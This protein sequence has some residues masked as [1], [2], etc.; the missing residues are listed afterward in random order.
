MPSFCYSVRVVV[1]TIGHSTR[2]LPEFVTLLRAHGITAVADV[3][4][5]PG[6]G[7]HPHFAREALAAGLAREALG[8]VWL[9]GLGGRRH[10]R[11]DSP[12]VA[13]R[14]ASFRA[15]ADHMETTEF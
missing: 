10:G 13:W 6:S 12:H 14:S 8:Y 15:Y 9:A 5:H 4:R 11:P 2:T 7:R 1:H 3:R